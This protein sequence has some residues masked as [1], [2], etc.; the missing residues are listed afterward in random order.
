MVALIGDAYSD[1][2]V[3]ASLVATARKKPMISYAATSSELSDKQ[4]HSYFFRSV[5]SDALQAA[6]LA[7]FLLTYDLYV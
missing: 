4:I 3:Q 2:S 5:P 7:Q 6:F 1:Y